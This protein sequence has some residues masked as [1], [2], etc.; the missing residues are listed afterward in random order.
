MTGRLARLFW[1]AADRVDYVVGLARCWAVDV[2]YEPEPPTS[3]DKQRAA[4][5]KKLG[6]AFPMIGL[7]GTIAAEGEARTR[8]PTR[9][10]IS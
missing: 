4:E 8:P 3:A 6:E 10:P 7:K 5:H 1:E 2:I 9:D